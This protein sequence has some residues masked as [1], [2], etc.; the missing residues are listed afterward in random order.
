MGI[1]V[2]ANQA[3]HPALCSPRKHSPHQPASNDDVATYSAPNLAQTPRIVDVVEHYALKPFVYVKP[4]IDG[5]LKPKYT[6]VPR[7]ERCDYTSMLGGHEA[8]DER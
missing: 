6:T 4:S 7:L 5:V 8:R 1:I 2:K 3:A